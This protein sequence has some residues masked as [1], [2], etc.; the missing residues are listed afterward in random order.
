MVCY[1]FPFMRRWTC[2][3]TGFFRVRWSTGSPSPPPSV[4]L[5]AF[6]TWCTSSRIYLLLQVYQTLQHGSIQLMLLFLGFIQASH[7][8]CNVLRC[9][10]ESPSIRLYVIISNSDIFSHRISCTL[11]GIPSIISIMGSHGWTTTYFT[12]ALL[13]ILPLKVTMILQTC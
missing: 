2:I 8:G 6:W 13:G 4:A 10:L 1:S 12:T 3:S 7:G 11:V 5:T 9:L